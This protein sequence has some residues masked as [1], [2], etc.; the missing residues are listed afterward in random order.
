MATISRRAI[1]KGGGA[2]VVSFAIG[3]Q[4]L[5]QARAAHTVDSFLAIH[6]D[7]SVTIFTSHVDIGTGISTVFRQVAA[8]ELDIPVERFTVIEGDTATTPDHGGTGGSTG[9][10]R[11]AADIRQ[12]AATARRALLELAARRM[13]RRAS[14]L[15]IEAGEIQASD[16]AAGVSIASLIGG[17]RF[18]LA[19]DPK[20]PLKQ[21]SE[22]RIVGQPVLR[23]DVPFKCTG[24]HVYLQDFSVPGMLHGRVVRPPT[25]GGELVSY[26]ETAIRAIPDIK[27][28]RIGNFLG[29]VA[30]DEWAAIRAARELK[31]VWKD[32]RDLPG[33]DDLERYLRESP[34]ADQ[35]VVNR[36]DASGA[37]SGAAKK[38]SAA[39]YWPFQSHASLGPSCAIADV[40]DAGITVWSASQGAF[41]LRA[42]LANVFGVAPENVRVIY[43][44]GSGSYGT[45]GAEDAAA[46]A[47][48]LSRAARRPVRVQWMRQ[49]EH[50]WDPKGPVQLLDV[51]ASVD[52][53]GNIAA[54][55][56][57]MWLPG[58]PPGERALAGPEL[59]GMKQGH[60]QG[61]GL[62]TMNAD[63]PYRAAHVRVV[64]H[65]LRETPLR[66][67]NLRA[68]GKIA[69][70]FAVEGFT[71]ELAAAARVDA[72]EYRRR[73]L[74]DPRALAVL[75]RA[76]SMIG[77]RAR[78][79]PN[80]D[81]AQGN[82]RVGR[83]IAYLRYKQAENY[84]ALAM[85]V[86]VERSTGRITVRRI[87][88]AHDC[89]LIMNP[90]GLRNQVEGNIMHTLSR[91][92]HE[93]VRF[94]Q[95]K[96]IS[97]DWV[98]YPVLRFPEAPPVEIALINRPDQPPYGAGE[99]A[100]APVAA[101]LANAVFDATG[102]RLR[103]VPFA[104]ER[105]KT[106]LARA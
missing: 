48:L 47:V 93:E 32:S 88:C 85:E 1:L 41:G 91:A 28:I 75:D 102:I 70:V 79:S 20:A 71:D 99:A 94:D 77:W 80:P 19:V 83:G 26:D 2:M 89:G 16:G 62:M 64:A 95:S 60:G 65:N 42:H 63:P 9:V 18:D 98:T 97:V 22:Y 66:L 5:A 6:Q 61:A 44:D 67:S 55:E 87:A 86:A 40:T 96:V 76:A 49:D 17:K 59:A 78:P 92:L 54:W 106:M 29:V 69:N 23:A 24:R 37:L 51:R 33:S 45:N 105:M 4:A 53:A 52:A 73:S 7:G 104:A 30:A 81:A 82:F 90:D 25:L 8:E 13:N 35:V 46:D 21:P 14:D 72:V 36:G 58:G 3:R 15:T 74:D 38:F 68:P 43:M 12:A 11:G 103:R 101:A 56:T 39:Y 27:V 31:V 10:P 57:E 50:G 34:A 100:S 84:C